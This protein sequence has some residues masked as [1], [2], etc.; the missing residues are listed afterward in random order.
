MVWIERGKKQNAEPWILLGLNFETP[1]TLA[2][3]VAMPTQGRKFR[4]FSSFSTRQSG[5][6]EQ[7]TSQLVSWTSFPSLRFKLLKNESKLVWLASTLFLTINAVSTFLFSKAALRMRVLSLNS[8][9]R[10]VFIPVAWRL[11]SGDFSNLNRSFISL[12]PSSSI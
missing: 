11:A 1:F 5:S 3:S 7:T 8:R 4:K 10:S 6:N 2:N 9:S 12:Q